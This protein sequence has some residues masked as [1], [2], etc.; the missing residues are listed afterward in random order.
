MYVV[1]DVFKA[2]PGSAKAL[3]EKFKAAISYI[4]S[5]RVWGVRL[6][7]DTVAGYWTVVVEWEVE[8]MDDYFNMHGGRAADPRWGEAMEGYMDLVDGGH[9]EI[10]T[11]ET[12][13]TKSD[14]TVGDDT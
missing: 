3:V 4:E 2:K 5:T 6:I 8:E 11:V 12:A 10:F 13:W 9:R 7:T 14:I 1:R